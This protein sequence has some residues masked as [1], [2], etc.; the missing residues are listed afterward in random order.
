MENDDHFVSDPFLYLSKK[1]TEYLTIENLQQYKR[2][3]WP[4]YYAPIKWDMISLV[5]N[6]IW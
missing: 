3:C 4:G 5:Q 2:L 1:P 6:Q